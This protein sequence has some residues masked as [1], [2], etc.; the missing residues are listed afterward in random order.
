[1]L[2]TLSV[3][4]IALASSAFASAGV[5]PGTLTLK[6]MNT[7]N[8][9]IPHGVNSVSYSS[10]LQAH[11]NMRSSQ[12]MNT[13]LNTKSSI[14]LYFSPKG[15]IDK[16]INGTITVTLGP[17]FHCSITLPVE[18]TRDGS[19][20]N[21]RMSQTATENYSITPKSGSY[22]CVLD[23]IGAENFFVH[24]VADSSQGPSGN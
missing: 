13:F 7:T 5:A 9:G 11:T 14:E 2:R 8:T 3:L 21:Y 12:R 20:T 22:Y 10:G 19:K 15:Q 23:L 4:L 6:I 18:I 17:P 1:M 24:T 16:T